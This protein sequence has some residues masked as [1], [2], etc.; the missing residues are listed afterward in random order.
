MAFFFSLNS[1]HFPLVRLRRG[2][3]GIVSTRQFHRRLNLFERSNTS[4]DRPLFSPVSFSLSCRPFRESFDT[5]SLRTS[6]MSM[7]KWILSP[8]RKCRSHPADTT[9]AKSA[10]YGMQYSSARLLFAH[11]TA[12]IDKLHMA[13]VLARAP[14]QRALRQSSPLSISVYLPRK[15]M[16]KHT[17]NLA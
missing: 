17:L 8:A 4:R 5:P 11:I 9:S 10:A 6:T 3:G 15:F 2:R 1:A 12:F 7:T 16:V 14:L 13:E